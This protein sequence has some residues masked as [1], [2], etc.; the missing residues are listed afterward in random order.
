MKLLTR[1]QIIEEWQ[2]QSDEMLDSFCC[3]KCRDIL[4]EYADRYFCENEY[5][6]QEFILKSEVKP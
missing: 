2:K 1:R 5:C 3:P 4:Y 6:V